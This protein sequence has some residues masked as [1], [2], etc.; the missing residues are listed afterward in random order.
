[1]DFLFAKRMSNLGTEGAFE[2][3]ARARALEA[4][5][6]Q[7]IHL[8]IG[9][10]DFDTPANIKE[11]A[12]KAMLDGYTHYVPAPGIKEAREAI[13]RY[14]GG[15]RGV[16][17]LPEEI[18]ITAGA[19]PVMYF[20]ITALVEEG[21]EVIYP[22]P[23]YPIYESIIN[24]VGAK[25]IPL[26]YLE[27][28]NFKPDL[29]LLKKLITPKTRMLIIN[30]PH[31]PTGATM[32]ME[33]L[34]EIANLVRGKNIWVMADEIY[35]RIAYGIPTPTPSIFSLP[36]M[37]DQTIIIDGFSKI[38]AM[39]GW[40]LGFGVAP[41]DVIA[42]M[43]TLSLNTYSHATAF[44]QMAGIEAIQGPQEGPAKMVEEFAIRRE[45]FVKALN[46]I[47]GVKCVAPQGAFYVFPSFRGYNISS[48]E[49]ATRLLN[50]AGVAGLTGTAFG[51]YGQGHLRFSFANS[52]DNIKIAVEKI[53]DFLKNL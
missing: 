17:V 8:E 12:Y 48:Q 46:D 37:K 40:R 30:T 9:E 25:S 7:V 24:F 4:Q 16:E 10:P 49:L 36:G 11:A 15:L 39:T 45:H 14:T 18:I 38:Y 13:A 2:V 51:I 44:V 33:E 42:K 52:L 21:E 34:E 6:K 28:S 5:G 32:S 27:E 53:G 31:N 35:N 50:E 41:K 29:D 1:M 20:A 19:K 22:N 23:G 47:P 26:P 43:S 3:L